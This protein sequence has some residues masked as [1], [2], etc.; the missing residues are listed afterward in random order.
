M[1]GLTEAFRSTYVPP[2][3]IDTHKDSIGIAIPNA[4]VLVLREDG[5]ECEDNEP[6]ELVHRG[7]LVAQGYWNAPEKTAQRFKTRSIIKGCVLPEMVVWSGD[8]VRRDKDGYLYFISRK[9]D[10]IKTS[11]YRVSPNEIEEV[12]YQ[13]KYSGEAVA[14]GIEHPVIGQAILL[15]V[16]PKG[17]LFDSNSLIKHCKNKFPTFMQPAEIIVLDD[18][19]RN[20][21]GKIDLS[22]IHISEPTR[23]K[24]R[25]SMP[26]SA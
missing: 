7:A 9:D 19:P 10:M 8:T 2:E 21:N 17:E 1:Y 25:S 11:G 18:L 6:G 20:Q 16:T 5:T 15:L 26:S 4:E 13:Y 24:T 14:L 3:N 12:V 22:L 23:L